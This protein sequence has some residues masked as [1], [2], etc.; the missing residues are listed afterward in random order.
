MPLL[1][2]GYRL[3]ALLL[4]KN[5]EGAFMDKIIYWDSH[6]TV[7]FAV[8]ELERLMK[9]AGTES[10]ISDRASFYGVK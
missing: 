10:I 3:R 9:G 6:E 2:Y 4:I 8:E 5:K 1:R 7:L